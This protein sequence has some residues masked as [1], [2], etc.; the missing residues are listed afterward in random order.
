M[1]DNVIITNS[2]IGHTGL[3]NTITPRQVL[4]TVTE[5]YILTNSNLIYSASN[6]G[7]SIVA[8]KFK[9]VKFIR[10]FEWN[11]YRI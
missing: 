4:D 9:N 1:Y 7:F 5:F 11:E 8:S 3:A 10:G 6:S 2:D